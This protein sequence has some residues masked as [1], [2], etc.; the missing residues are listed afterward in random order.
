M[1]ELP[2]VTVRTRRGSCGT[3]ADETA[4]LH[5]IPSPETLAGIHRFRSIAAAV[6]V[7]TTG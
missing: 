1:S 4:P 3:R 5:A 6:C 2:V 7:N